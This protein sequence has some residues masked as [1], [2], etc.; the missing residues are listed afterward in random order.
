[1]AILIDPIDI[2]KSKADSRKLMLHQQEAVDSM[3]EYFN[4]TGEKNK[5]QSG[6]VVMPTGSGKTFTAVNWLLNSGVANGYKI[7]W[8]VHRQD[9]ITQTYKEFRNQAPCLSDHGIK[10][11][12]MIPISGV[13]YRMSQASRYDVNVCSISSVASKHG[14]RFIRRMLG[15]NGMKKVIIVIDEAHHAVSPSYKKVIKRIT[16]LNPNRILL[17]LTATPIRMQDA[18]QKRLMK[19]FNVDTN[20]NSKVGGKKGY[21]YEEKLKNLLIN[22]SLAKPIYKRVDTKIDGDIEYSLS[23]ED[24]EFF[25]KFGEL[26]EAIKTKIA[27]ST[28]R[29]KLILNEYLENE[30]T[31]GKTLIFA[32]N[33]LHC[34]TLHKEFTDAGISCDYVISDK[35]GAQDTILEFKENK[36]KVLINVQILTEGSDVPDIQSIFLT[37]QTNSDSLLMQMIGRGLRGSDYGGT[38][39]AYII[40]F[41]DTWDKFSFWLDPKVLDIFKPDPPEVDI[42]LDRDVKK[43]VEEIDE[44]TNIEEKPIENIDPNPNPELYDV[45]LR[46]YNKIRSK[47]ISKTSSEIFPEGWYSVLDD[48][49]EDYKVLVFDNQLDGYEILNNNISKYIEKKVNPITAISE[50]FDI[51]ENLPDDEEFQFILEM[52]YENKEMPEY[53][54]FEQRNL[55]DPKKIYKEMIAKVDEEEPE[56]WLERLYY[57][58]PIL[59]ELYKIFYIFKKTVLNSPIET[60]KAEIEMIDERKNLNI[61]DNYYNLDELLDEIIDEYE[62]MNRKNLISIRW[63]NKINKTWF[64]LCQRYTDENENNTYNILINKILSSPDVPREVVKFLIYHEMLHKSG[65]WDHDEKFRE[66]EWT[67]PNSDEMDGFLD[68]LGIRYDMDTIFNNRKKHTKKNDEI[69]TEKLD[70]KDK[71]D[72]DLK[73]DS[74]EDLNIKKEEIQNYKFCRDCGNKLPVEAKFCDKCGSNTNY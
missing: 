52:I 71:L 54:S 14:F 12:K 17:G 50:C 15:T 67:Y 7:V 20:R 45:Y 11:L 21:V 41:H 35:K 32:V 59:Q 56:E 51:Q 6:I 49:G 64:G 47:I 2:N 1:M 63:S 48:E 30:D 28:I 3:N 46:I 34:K 18:D 42:E 68:E 26:S 16:D 60:T 58:T 29:N 57:N 66:E 19:I 8:L 25:N 72:N 23:K 73:D 44:N 13:H 62:F 33:Q 65:Y 36:F 69:E 70:S 22:G 38:K 31:Y 53:Y 37:R 10:K 39:E 24:E 55:I 9:L 5:E 27:L 40:D 74:K 61:I 4:L 43:K